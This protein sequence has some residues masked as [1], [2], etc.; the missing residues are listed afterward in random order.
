VKKARSLGACEYLVDGVNLVGGFRSKFEGIGKPTL[1]GRFSGRPVNG[2][3]S[4]KGVP[5][6]RS[7]FQRGIACA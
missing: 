7:A 1:S 2:V 5:E 6:P 4:M 3:F